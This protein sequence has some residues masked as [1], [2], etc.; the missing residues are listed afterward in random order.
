MVILCPYRQD[1]ALFVRG[2]E[3]ATAREGELDAF[4]N[5]YMPANGGFLTNMLYC[6]R[7]YTITKRTW[8]APGVRNQGRLAI[9]HFD[10]RPFAPVTFAVT[11]LSS[12]GDEQA[13]L[14]GAPVTF[15]AT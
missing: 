3:T 11:R 13:S 10:W 15:H 7:H 8:P 12:T 9:S 5:F 14:E 6:L 4:P 2:V 1:L